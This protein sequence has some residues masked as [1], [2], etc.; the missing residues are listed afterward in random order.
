MA[1]LISFKIL[2]SIDTSLQGQRMVTLATQHIFGPASLVGAS[3]LG[4]RETLEGTQPCV[5]CLFSKISGHLVK[6]TSLGKD[7]LLPLL[8]DFLF[9]DLVW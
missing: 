3:H 6:I 8:Q 2:S 4:F 5:L 9:G 1:V 7:F